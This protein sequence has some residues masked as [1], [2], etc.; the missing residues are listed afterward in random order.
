MEKSDKLGQF[1]SPGAEQYFL[2]KKNMDRSIDL[3]V[4]PMQF[5]VWA[6]DSVNNLNV[7]VTL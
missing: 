7:V 3:A 5:L 1:R 6:K 4:Q 2:R